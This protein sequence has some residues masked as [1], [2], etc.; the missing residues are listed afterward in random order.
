MATPEYSIQINRI[1]FNIYKNNIRIQPK[2]VPQRIEFISITSSNYDGKVNFTTL[3]S[4]INEEFRTYLP[5][6]D[7]LIVSADKE[8]VMAGTQAGMERIASMARRFSEWTIAEH[9]ISSELESGDIIV[10]DGSLQ[11]S[12][13]KENIYVN[14][15][16][17]KAEEKI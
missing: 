14:N 4:P 5:Q 7:L 15:L 2:S 1:Y 9:L 13:I 12:F 11:T 6:P 10:K 17:K 8:D 3:I 16:F